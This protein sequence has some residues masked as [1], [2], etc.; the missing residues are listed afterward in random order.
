VNGDGFPD[1][2]I[3][4]PFFISPEAPL[5]YFND[6]TGHFRTIDPEIFR[7]GD[8]FFGKNTV[9]LDLNGDGVVDFVHRDRLPGPDG[10]FA[11]ADDLTRL[12]ASIGSLAQAPPVLASAI[13]PG[14]RAILAGTTATVFAT[15]LASGPATALECSI[16]STNLPA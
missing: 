9:P 13:L 10:L 14:S 1:L 3:T 5:V 12:I 6:G 16:A 15:V 7:A 11:T 4:S 2:V 8:L